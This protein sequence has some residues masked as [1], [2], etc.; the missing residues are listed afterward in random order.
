MNALLL[1]GRQNHVR[2]EV[3]EQ[4]SVAA[5]P[6]ADV[7]ADIVMNPF[8]ILTQIRVGRWHLRLVELN[9]RVSFDGISQ[10]LHHSRHLRS[11]LVRQQPASERWIRN[12]AR[13]RGFPYGAEIGDQLLCFFILFFCRIYSWV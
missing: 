10:L 6:S 7:T 5:P 13:R 2:D 8:A 11:L 4:L 3:R 12:T 9:P 1:R